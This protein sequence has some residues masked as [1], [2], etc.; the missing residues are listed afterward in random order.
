MGT[1]GT[2]YTTYKIRTN[3]KSL[4]VDSSLRHEDCEDMFKGFLDYIESIMEVMSKAL[5]AFM[6]SACTAYPTIVPLLDW[7]FGHSGVG[8]VLGFLTGTVFG[9]Q[10]LFIYLIPLGKST[11]VGG[12]WFVPTSW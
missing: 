12:E 6:N 8:G 10:G 9:Q 7:D 4:P 3:L 1:D 2:Y 11:M 5:G